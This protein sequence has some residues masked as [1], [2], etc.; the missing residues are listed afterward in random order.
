MAS[1]K[2]W[3]LKKV[4]DNFPDLLS[5]N[6][7]TI[8]EDLGNSRMDKGFMETKSS[9]SASD[10]DDLKVLTE[11]FKSEMDSV[12]SNL[13][14]DITSRMSLQDLVNSQLIG[15]LYGKG[16]SVADL[17]VD[18]LQI[19][20][21]LIPE[22]GPQVENTLD[23]IAN[24]RSCNSKFSLRSFAKMLEPIMNEKFKEILK[25]VV[26]QVYTGQ[27]LNFCQKPF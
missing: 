1:I 19:A 26:T 25:K 13:L 12:R 10:M 4:E 23:T 15:S 14:K 7:E 18:Y 22:L 11:F 8:K 5:R 9:E 3:A 17:I 24:V 20:K 21:I 6:V 27:H 16:E 2:S